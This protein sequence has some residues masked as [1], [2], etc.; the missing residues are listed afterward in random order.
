MREDKQEMPIRSSILSITNIDKSE[1]A[2]VIICR[3]TN[4]KI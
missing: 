2:E 4:V 3:K 1:A